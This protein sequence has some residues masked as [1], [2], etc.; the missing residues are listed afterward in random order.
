MF[1][2]HQP[3]AAAR[4]RIG[5]PHFEAL[6]FAGLRG[7]LQ[8][9]VCEARQGFAR[10]RRFFGKHFEPRQC[11]E[12]EA[13]DCSPDDFEQCVHGVPVYIAWP[14]KSKVVIRTLSLPW[15]LP[16]STMRAGWVQKP[17]PLTR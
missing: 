11:E 9:S 12:S 7:D 2:E 15:A 14:V 6:R 5:Y 16:G 13:A 17:R 1:D 3:L 8:R 10:R 4:R